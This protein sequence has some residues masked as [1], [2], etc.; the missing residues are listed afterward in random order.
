MIPI[1]DLFEQF[2]EQGYAGPIPVL[3]DSD[4]ARVLQL[5]HAR[6]IARP[7]DWIKGY[8][9]T[10]RI[11]YE[12]GTHPNILQVVSALLGEDVLL[13]G[14]SLQTRAPNEIHHWHT[15]IESSAAKGRTVAV[16]VGI[17]NSTSDSCL[18]MM[19]YTHLSDL[20][21][22]ELRHQHG[23]KREE[24]TSED[25]LD[26]ARK[27][28]ER[29]CV[30]KP[31]VKDGQ[32][33]FFDGR[34]WHYSRNLMNTTRHALLL[35]YAAPEVAVRIPVPDHL[36]WPFRYLAQ[37]RP[38]CLVVGGMDR[39]AVNRIVSPP[40]PETEQVVRALP[41]SV[42][43]IDVPLAPD[44][45]AGWKPYPLFD[46]STLSAQTFSCHAS[47]LIHDEIPHPPHTHGEEEILFLLQGEI[48]VILPHLKGPGTKRKRLL[49]G[50]FVYYPA[51][52]AHTL[53][54]ISKEP[55]NYMM[56][57]WKADPVA[58]AESKLP[59]GQFSMQQ[60]QIAKEGFYCTELVSGA[61][62]CL[63]KLQCHQST[64]SPGTG[65]EPHVD[66]Y[67]VVI[68]VLEGEIETLNQRVG[69]HTVI[70]YPAGEPHGLTN[71]GNV[72]AKYVVFEFHPALGPIS[73]EPLIN[74]PS[75][76]TKLKDSKR[77]KRRVRNV[78]KRFLSPFRQPA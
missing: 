15:D 42:R 38:P 44:A 39:F 35:Q 25:A 21:V 74:P 54:T 10:S 17:E 59:F 46:G 60:N 32:A 8:A 73:S 77:W 16:W 7:L 71:P 55:A 22:Q 63:A 1:K 52:F 20:T 5:S 75:L 68:L 56:L 28:D 6:P 69:P 18:S 37:P 2:V 41:S 3:S 72:M 47:V 4:R 23:K 27:L 62:S 53:Q 64:V 58:A 31:E 66:A 11:F 51:G 12:L 76:F 33:I 57:K 40:L 36:D 26:W 24:T 49:P 45:V 61:T 34:V 48:E 78:A 50:D 67:D 30:V 43:T 65:Y 9:A 19:A 13:W 29:A 14:A 70:F